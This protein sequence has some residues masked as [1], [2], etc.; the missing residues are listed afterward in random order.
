MSFEEFVLDYQPQATWFYRLS[1]S[2]LLAPLRL[3]AVVRFDQLQEDLY[4]LPPIAAA[5]QAA[6]EA[7]EFS[8]ATAC[9]GRPLLAGSAPLLLPFVLAAIKLLA[10]CPPG[11]GGQIQH[12][13]PRSR[14]RRSSDTLLTACQ[15][16][17]A[18]QS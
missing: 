18:L 14:R 12:D 9:P 5:L 8:A 16:P 4:R 17:A 2:E 11:V 6:E 7:R 15:T 1:Q 13:V 3:D 10:D